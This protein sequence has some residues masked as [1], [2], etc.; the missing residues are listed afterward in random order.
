MASRNQEKIH[1]SVRCRP[2]TEYERSHR[3]KRVVDCLPSG[4][5]VNVVTTTG[6]LGLT[7]S[8]LTKTYAFDN[9]FGPNSSQIDVYNAVVSG[10]LQ[11]VL[12][13]YNCTVL[14]Y[15]Q[16]GTG[17]T[18]TMEGE[19]TR[20]QDYSWDTD[21]RAGIIPRAL[22]Q[23]FDQLVASKSEFSVR[24]SLLEIYNEEIY[25]LLSP[26]SGMVKMKIYDDSSRKGSVVVS[27][28]TEVLVQH[29]SDV[30]EILQQGAAKR[31]T[32]AT[33]LNEFSSRSH[34]VFSV[35]VHSKDITKNQM[36]EEELIKIG[37]LNLVDLAGSEN[38]G[39]S[40]AIDKRAREAG[41]INT[42][43]LTLGRCITALV[44]R[45]PHVPYRESKLTRL[46]QDSL[47]G[48]TK[49]SIIATVSPGSDNLEETLSTLDYAYRSKNIHNRPKVNQKLT[50]RALIKE[51]DE[52][53]RRLQR[54]IIATRDKNG[55]YLDP[56]QYQDMQNK[57]EELTATLQMRNEEVEK[58]KGLFTDTN[59]ELSAIQEVL[60]TTK[61]E[62]T[63][64]RFLKNAHIEHGSEVTAQANELLTTANIVTEDIVKVHDKVKR[65][66]TANNANL[67]MAET[68]AERVKDDVSLLQSGTLSILQQTTSCMDKM[69]A[70]FDLMKAKEDENCRQINFQMS[71]FKNFML[72]AY[73]ENCKCQKTTLDLMNSLDEKLSASQIRH[74]DELVRQMESLSTKINTLTSVSTSIEDLVKLIQTS[75]QFQ[76]QELQM[77]METLQNHREMVENLV[78]DT[79][80]QV[81]EMISNAQVEVDTMKAQMDE[82]VKLQKQNLEAMFANIDKRRNKT[83]S[84]V[85]QLVESANSIATSSTESTTKQMETIDM[86]NDKASKSLKHC[87]AVIASTQNDQKEHEQNTTEIVKQ[88]CHD[89]NS[90]FKET[91]KQTDTLLNS[92]NQVM[93]R[94]TDKGIELQEKCNAAA[95]DM[96]ETNAAQAQNLEDTVK[97]ISKKMSVMEEAVSGAAESITTEVEEYCRDKLVRVLPTGETPARKEYKYA[98]E[99]V[100]RPEEDELMQKFEERLLAGELD[101]DVEELDEEDPAADMD[102]LESA[103]TLSLQSASSMDQD[104]NESITIPSGGGVPFFTNRNGNKSRQA[105]VHSSKTS[106]GKA[107]RL[108]LRSTQNTMN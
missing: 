19:R 64:Q 59:N 105:K 52:E 4:N 48:C 20:G 34:S 28:L 60:Q 55:I 58:Y 24:V 85:K 41:N 108:P 72:D 103:E 39:R 44:D 104:L 75:T 61:T 5:E 97:E 33:D 65:V 57:I 76:R 15:G 51:Y 17:K 93:E 80:N 47:G 8:Q 18:F 1:V 23:L 83:V 16:T 7:A 45:A 27:G 50:K 46:L 29:K 101:S 21:P 95:S 12:A 40:G 53:I 77:Q 96:M 63:Q 66:E 100:S 11:D 30:Y 92:T 26:S 10:Q 49:T 102:E 68:V 78:E 87:K 22:S 67:S 79:E 86:L 42:S 6:G 43:L 69:V 71:L 74:K 73:E 70:D 38:I 88:L 54:E 81:N 35:T 9:V 56:K 37:K 98:R 25:D 89:T 31:R 107:T 91:N 84:N 36:E 99:I 14:A 62:L 82:M 94:C 3:V 90:L 2:M 32:A 13:G 106:K